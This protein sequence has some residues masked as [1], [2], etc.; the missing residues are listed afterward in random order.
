[1]IADLERGRQVLQA[2]KRAGHDL[3]LDDFGTG[4]SSLTYLHRFPIA[5]VKVD[6]SFVDGMEH[7][8]EQRAICS[9]V[10][11]LAAGLKLVSVAEGVETEAQR[12]AL[13]EMGFDELQGFLLGRPVAE[14]RYMDLLRAAT[15]EP[16][17]AG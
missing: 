12:L 1:M 7:N 14:L 3:A 2:I 8:P 10:Q 17:D 9:A 16:A 5:K 13:C 4:F 6:R 15:A 11:A